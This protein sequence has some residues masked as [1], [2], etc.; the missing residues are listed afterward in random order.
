MS[1]KEFQNNWSKDRTARFNKLVRLMLVTEI[2]L[3]YTLIHLIGKRCITDD[4]CI[5]L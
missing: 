2:K 4:N 1:W 3:A 5:L